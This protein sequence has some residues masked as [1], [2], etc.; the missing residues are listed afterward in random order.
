MAKS[1]S[2]SIK[3]MKVY[4]LSGR[5]TAGGAEC[6]FYKPH[7]CSKI[8]YKVYDLKQDAAYAFRWQKKLH[9]LGF[10]PKV[11]GKLE[12]FC[13]NGGDIK[14]GYKTEVADT[15]TPVNMWSDEYEELRKKLSKRKI[16]FQDDHSKNVGKIN[17]KLVVIDCGPCSFGGC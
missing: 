7:K 8:G 4:A 12:L 1:V 10:A 9:K 5:R 3:A 2:V 13:H 15:T 6:S 11:V 14:W 17:G 16:Y